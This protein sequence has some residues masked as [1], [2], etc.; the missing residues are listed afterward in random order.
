MCGRFFYNEVINTEKIRKIIESKYEQQILQLWKK[1]DIYPGDV[2]LTCTQQDYQLMKWQYDLFGRKMINT[3]IESAEKDFYKNS[4]E[5]NRCVILASGFYEWDQ[6]KV[7]YY[8]H[9]GE[10]PIYLAGIYQENEVLNGYSII[11]TEAST[12]RSIHPRIPIV[13]NQQQAREYLKGEIQPDVLKDIKPD[14]TIENKF[15]NLSLF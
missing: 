13:L 1:D 9:T 7:K 2:S 5:N 11:T 12:S 10:Q 15:E 3:R 4:F 14:F 8:L 6:D